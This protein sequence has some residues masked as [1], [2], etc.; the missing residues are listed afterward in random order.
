MN[1][2]NETMQ[3]SVKQ[4][5]GY[6]GLIIHERIT[7][8]QTNIIFTISFIS[9]NV[10]YLVYLVNYATVGY[11]HSIIMSLKTITQQMS[12]IKSKLT[13]NSKFLLEKTTIF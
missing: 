7:E 11:I 6:D 10:K 13:S 1:D 5:E 12:E 4:A 8:L 9:I 3:R 2:I